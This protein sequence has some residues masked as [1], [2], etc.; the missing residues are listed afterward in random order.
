MHV[1]HVQ[2]A[3]L[4]ILALGFS[5]LRLGDLA[6]KALVPILDPLLRDRVLVE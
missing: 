6:P 1:Q 4:H 3:I 5:A 2:H